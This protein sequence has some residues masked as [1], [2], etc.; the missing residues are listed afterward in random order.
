MEC[1]SGMPVSRRQ[2][3]GTVLGPARRARAPK[4]GN[5]H[6]ICQSLPLN[7]REERSERQSVYAYVL[8]NLVNFPRSQR[9]GVPPSGAPSLGFAGIV[10][11]LSTVPFP[12]PLGTMI[13]CRICFSTSSCL[14]IRS[15]Q[16]C[17]SLGW[18]ECAAQRLSQ[19]SWFPA[20]LRHYASGSS[21]GKYRS[22][23]KS[24]M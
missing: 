1:R 14:P 15:M 13:L 7:P 24:R 11:N 10:G 23:T 17:Q 5:V 16:Y 3:L 20:Y 18:R 12:F 22:N 21:T 8:T 9:I 2:Y 19:T 6:Q 4:D